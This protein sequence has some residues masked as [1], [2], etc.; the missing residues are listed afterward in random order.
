MRRL[1]SVYLLVAAV[2]LPAAV[3]SPQARI[4]TRAGI[5]VVLP[6]GWHLA[7]TPVTTCSDPVQRLVVT[8]TR[9]RLH[10][11]FRIPPRS[12]LVLL[13]ESRSG[14]RFPPRPKSFRLPRRLDNLGGCC[15]IPNGPGV[16]L[17]FRDHGRRFYAFV[18][19]GEHARA[20]TR[21]ATVR[22]LNSLR[23]SPG[24]RAST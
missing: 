7:R 11:A 2:S 23:V 24:V 12:A 17:L 22:L 3:A 8:T 14:G 16:E 15:E 4:H 9:A 20:A 10:R 13:M 5:S 6:S 18:Y 21:R 19:V 1:L